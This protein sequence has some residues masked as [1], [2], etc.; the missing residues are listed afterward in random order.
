MKK[1]IE[2]SIGGISFTIEDDAY[3]LL[4]DYLRRFENT[5]SDPREARE[6]MEDVEAR[7]AEIFHKELKYSNQVVGI[8]L[9]QVVINHL[10]EVEEAGDKSDEQ[11]KTS[12]TS[13]I[14]DEGYTKGEK[15]LYRDPDNKMISGVCGGIAAYL[16]IDVTI[17]RIAFVLCFFAYSTGFWIYVILWIV[18]PVAKTVAQKLAMRGYAPTAENI[19]RY[20]YEK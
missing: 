20:T 15:R 14:N 16:G 9:V 12:A 10:G 13:A 3:F 1:V 5:I 6:V 11:W 7:V 17:V 8:E 4:K 19:R 2:V 18:S